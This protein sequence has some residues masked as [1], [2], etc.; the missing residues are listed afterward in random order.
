M[1]EVKI[2]DYIHG[3]LFAYLA[4]GLDTDDIKDISRGISELIDEAYD[5]GFDD[6]KNQ[7]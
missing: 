6:G 3:E 5:D 2:S 4:E 1:K 7:L